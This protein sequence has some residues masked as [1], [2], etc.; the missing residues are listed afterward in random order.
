MTETTTL[1]PGFTQTV[2]ADGTVTITP[3]QEST[4]LPPSQCKYGRHPRAELTMKRTDDGTFE[5]IDG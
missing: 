2:N 5:V 3:S 4:I 1:P